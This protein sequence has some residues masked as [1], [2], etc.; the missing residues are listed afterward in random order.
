MLMDSLVALQQFSG[1]H[2]S[3]EGVQ[4]VGDVNVV[5]IV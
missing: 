4:D 2:Q 1:S 5:S 3:C